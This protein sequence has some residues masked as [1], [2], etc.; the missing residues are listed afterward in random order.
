MNASLGMRHGSKLWNVR[1]KKKMNK[2]RQI[3]QILKSFYLWVY[4]LK[5]TVSE[6]YQVNMICFILY[7]ILCWFL[8]FFFDASKFI[9]WYKNACYSFLVRFGDCLQFPKVCNSKSKTYFFFSLHIEHV[10]LLLK[11]SDLYYFVRN[12]MSVRVDFNPIY[13]R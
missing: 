3:I 12:E 1:E 13:Y 10:C 7:L 5:Q 4:E 6:A 2:M 8:L 9:G 11:M